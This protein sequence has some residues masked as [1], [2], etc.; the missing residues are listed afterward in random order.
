MTV[1]TDRKWKGIN[2]QTEETTFR[3]NAEIW[4]YYVLEEEYSQQE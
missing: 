3:R 1:N 2:Q 4:E